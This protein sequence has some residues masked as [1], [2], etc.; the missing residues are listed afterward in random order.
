MTMW[1]VLTDKSTDTKKPCATRVAG[2][3]QKGKI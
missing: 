1:Y 2:N 3:Q